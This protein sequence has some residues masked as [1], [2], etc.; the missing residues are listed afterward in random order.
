[1]GNDEPRRGHRS[2]AKEAR[3]PRP[4]GPPEPVPGDIESELTEQ[5]D[6]GAF[7]RTISFYHADSAP[8]LDDEGK[9]H[10]EPP[11]KEMDELERKGL[12]I[13]PTI[14]EEIVGSGAAGRGERKTS[15]TLPVRVGGS[16][17]GRTRTASA[18]RP[19]RESGGGSK[20]AQELPSPHL[21]KPLDLSI[22]E[23]VAYQAIKRVFR[24]GLKIPIHK[25]GLADVDITIDDK[26]VLI[27]FTDMVADMPSLSV[28]RITFAYQG[29]PL[30][31]YGRGV[32]GDV[33]IHALPMARFLLRAWLDK[34][35]RM[36]QA[37]RET[38]G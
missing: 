37:K 18:E 10:P 26:E 11:Q 34:R 22:V 19:P 38:T 24:E 7:R 28:W 2:S 23:Q 4:E 5:W 30:V 3:P 8:Y 35:K 29:E 31:V 16:P 33:K 27:D 17:A 9:L 1:M 32:K 14:V 13:P 15:S 6:G 21:K 20:S 36:K 25:E 12:V